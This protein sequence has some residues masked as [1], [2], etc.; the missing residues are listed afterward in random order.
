MNPYRRYYITMKKIYIFP[1][2]W[3]Y[4]LNLIEQNATS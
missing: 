2:E 3:E 1:K 4:I